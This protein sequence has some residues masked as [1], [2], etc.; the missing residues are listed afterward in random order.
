MAAPVILIITTD[1]RFQ[2]SAMPGPNP[3]KITDGFGG[4]QLISRPRRV[5]FTQF[6]GRNPFS[7]QINL[8][9]DG[10]ADGKS[11]E[12]SLKTLTW[13]AIPP[14]G[15]RDPR[16]VRLFGPALPYP[17]S[18]E[19]VINGI[20]YGDNVIW[21]ELGR[22]RLRQ[23]V[24]ITLIRHVDSDAI[25]LEEAN[26]GL[27]VPKSQIITTK[28]GDTVRTLAAFFYGDSTLWHTIA[29]ANGIRDPAYAIKPQTRLRIP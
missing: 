13:M 14:Q 2:V 10:Y 17:S 23:D 9:F 1:N 20:E 19:W 28:A 26:P 21:D 18:G 16:K 12:N 27:S 29:D 8:M 24:T 6:Q 15:S 5:A 25:K 22:F 7:M 3:A 4:W 11:Q